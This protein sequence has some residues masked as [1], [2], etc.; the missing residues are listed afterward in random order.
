VLATAITV[1][2]ADLVC[3][4]LAHHPLRLSLWTAMR[5]SSTSQASAVMRSTATAIAESSFAVS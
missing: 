4:F 2:T 5:H 1:S 3:H